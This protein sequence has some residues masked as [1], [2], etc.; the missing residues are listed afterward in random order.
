MRMCGSRLARLA[1]L[2]HRGAGHG[3]GPLRVRDVEA[4]HDARHDL[5]VQ[6]VLEIVE[7][8][9]RAL[10]IGQRRDAVL[11]RVARVL[12]RQPHELQLLAALGHARDDATI[13]LLAQR[14]GEKLA[15]LEVRGETGSRAEAR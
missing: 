11:E 4:H 15:V 13:G 6:S 12:V 3:L 8:F 2:E 7:R 1:V 5:E 10:R 14:F 9:V